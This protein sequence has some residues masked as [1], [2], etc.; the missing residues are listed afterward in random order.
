MGVRRETSAVGMGC[1][2]HR[3]SIEIYIA[4]AASGR[5]YGNGV[6][7]TLTVLLLA[8][9][10]EQAPTMYDSFWSPDMQGRAWREGLGLGT[11]A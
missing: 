9:D 5:G 10:E 3:G 1:L 4:R 11:V 7:L 2:L 8:D 6:E